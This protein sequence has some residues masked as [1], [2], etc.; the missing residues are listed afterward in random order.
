M[1]RHLEQ[2]G[3]RAVGD[4]QVASGC[5]PSLPKITTS[6]ANTPGPSSAGGVVSLMGRRG[7]I[8]DHCENRK[9]TLSWGHALR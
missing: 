3:I 5:T 6:P 9:Q 2:P 1:V 4:G 7:S 8:T